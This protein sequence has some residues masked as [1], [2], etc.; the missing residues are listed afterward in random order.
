MS[1]PDETT[2]PQTPAWDQV[3][4]VLKPLAS[5]QLTV[6]L[7]ALA[8]VLVFFGTLAQMNDGIWTVVDQ[9][10]WSMVVW[11]P[12]DLIAKFGHVFFFLPTSVH[13]PGS[14]PFPA[15]K[16]LGFAMLVNLTAA[17][18][19][20]F[21]VTWRRAGILV[22]HAGLILLFVGEAITRE[23]QVEQRMIIDEGKSVNFAENNRKYELAF[24]RSEPDG[25]VVTA[26]PQS[27]LVPGERVSHPDLPYD[28]ETLEYM[29]NSELGNP[30]GDNRA[31]AGAGTEVI[32]KKLPQVSGVDTSQRDDV[33][34]VYVRFLDKATGAD[35]GTYLFSK[36]LKAEPLTV[37]DAKLT[38]ILRNVR[39]YKPFTIH[40]VD[41]RHDKY[42]GTESPKN[43]SSDIRLIDPE[44]GIDRTQ[45]IA[46]NEPLRHRGEAFYQ[47]SFDRA[48]ES[49]TVL[50]VVRNPGWMIPYVSCVM[51]GLGMAVHFGM[52]LVAFL[53]KQRDR[54]GLSLVAPSVTAQTTDPYV[55]W[56]PWAVLGLAAL[57]LLAHAGRMYPPKEP[58]NFVAASSIPVID[59][60]RVKPLD[61]FARVNLRVISGRETVKD[62][63]G[64]TVPAIKWFFD[65]VKA[66]QGFGRGP[67]SKYKF[68]KIDNDQVLATLKLEP[69][70]GFLYSISE[71][72]AEVQKLGKDAQA[73]KNKKRN[74]QPID[75]YE[76]KAIETADRLNLLVAIN[77]MS[78]PLV[79]PS[80]TN[81]EDYVPLPDALETL[82]E[83]SLKR[84]LPKFDLPLSTDTEKLPKE[85]QDKLAGPFAETMAAV[86]AENPAVAFWAKLFKAYS[87][88]KPDEFNQILAENA[89]KLTLQGATPAKMKLET[90]YN[91]FAPFYEC[92]GLYVGVILLCIASWFGH[93]EAF[94]KSAFW[95]MVLTAVIHGAALIARMS[96]QDRWL[97]FVTN[98]YS[99]AIFIGFGCVVL[100]LLLERVYPIGIGNLIGAILGV[101]TTIV[102]HQIGAGGDTL[103][104]MQAVLDT[105][106]WLATHVT[107]V[108]FGYTATFVAGAIGI[109]Y[110][111]AGLFT[112]AVTPELNKTFNN[113]LY[114]VVAFATLLSFVGTVLGG[115]W[116][117]QSWGRFWGWDPK[118]NGAVLIVIWNALILHARWAGLVKTRGIALLAIAGNMV[119]VWSWF[120]TN[121]LGIGLHA[122][123]FDNTLAMVCTGLWV[124]HAMLVGLGLVPLEHW[125][126]FM[127]KDGAATVTATTNRVS[128]AAAT[129]EPAANGNGP[130][131]GKKAKKRR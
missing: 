32:A 47:H 36:F 23:A 25:D 64:D 102:S 85:Q 4:K 1:A 73:A 7:F 106:F 44:Q 54:G 129:P 127:P 3:K 78:V 112:R 128:V 45:R 130:Q 125:L 27:R 49:Y 41:F 29:D 124:S 118:E 61:T 120:G 48:T 71:L 79:A 70:S 56:V 119:T 87:R 93:A 13:L 22:I 52:M 63:D 86:E 65:L 113:M 92:I 11:I 104:M 55:K 111:I 76:A 16:L 2:A 81:A 66:G 51:V 123:G 17:H 77:Q 83:E 24:V 57:Y 98:L 14:F 19:V 121:Q 62:A 117:D 74:N 10:F 116:A 69:R 110:V 94:R 89:D 82:R 84:V 105:N 114:G 108:T 58:Y 53:R 60:G 122:Y 21:R 91:A 75:L 28:L 95:L 39:Y 99:S 115:I 5:L 37:G 88:E 80:P 30:T 31:T 107:C 67:A 103:E 50:Q 59:G 18:L 126:S 90:F 97:V 100:G 6:V 38:A 12:F 40:L 8:M 131:A 72:G 109:A 9:Y 26:V 43:Y 96:I 35:K 15:G 68:I 42:T 33:P 46:M 34:S 101:L 20:R